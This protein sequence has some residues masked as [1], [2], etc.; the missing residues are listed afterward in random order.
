MWDAESRSTA[1]EKSAGQCDLSRRFVVIDRLPWGNP[2]RFHRPAR[3]FEAARDA[4]KRHTAVIE[5][6]HPLMATDGAKDLTNS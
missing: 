3:G 2:A 4:P 1:A 5:M 6:K